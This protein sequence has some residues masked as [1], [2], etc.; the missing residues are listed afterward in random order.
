MVKPGTE[1]KPSSRNQINRNAQNSFKSDNNLSKTQIQ[2]SMGN[3]AGLPNSQKASTHGA[4][5]IPLLDRRKE[6]TSSSSNKQKMNQAP[7]HLGTE[8]P[9]S[10]VNR[11]LIRPS[12]K[13]RKTNPSPG[14]ENRAKPAISGTG[15]GA[16]PGATLQKPITNITVA[17]SNLQNYFDN[18]IP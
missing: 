6:R 14:S 4:D 17:G 10:S 5:D 2:G 15:R 18:S 1:H 9:P 7:G 13:Q 12:S 11:N 3:F 8:L 16:S